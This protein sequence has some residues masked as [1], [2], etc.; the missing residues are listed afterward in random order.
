MIAYRECDIESILPSCLVRTRILGGHAGSPPRFR[1]DD[2]QHSGDSGAAPAE[3]KE[4][5]EAEEE[6]EEM[7]FDLFG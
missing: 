3:D 6:E 7:A 1:I 4:A 2:A 5:V